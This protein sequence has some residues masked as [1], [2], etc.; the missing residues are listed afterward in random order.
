MD[1]TQNQWGLLEPLLQDCIPPKQVS[2]RPRRH[3]REII[4]GILWVCRTGAPWKDMPA[5]YPPYQTC[6][7]RFQEWVDTD[8]WSEILATLAADLKKR[9]KIDVSEAFIDGSF[10]S[11]KKGAQVLGKRSGERVQRS[12]QSETAMVFLSPFAHMKPE[13]MKLLLLK[14]HYQQVLSAQNQND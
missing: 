7:R 8:T 9:G 5:R 11:A 14:K 1:L 6:H 10:A 2:G 4:N 12:W 13:P 3:D